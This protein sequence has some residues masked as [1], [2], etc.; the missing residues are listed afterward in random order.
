M[1]LQSLLPRHFSKGATGQS[2]G[3]YKKTVIDRERRVV[4]IHIG[5]E[6]VF[7]PGLNATVPTGSRHGLY[8]VGSLARMNVLVRYVQARSD[9]MPAYHVVRTALVVRARK[10]DESE[11]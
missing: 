11:E 10:D 3:S 1:H 8:D 2:A 5:E 4:E 9:G 7:A 6:I